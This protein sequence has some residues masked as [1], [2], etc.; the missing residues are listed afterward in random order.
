MSRGQRPARAAT[1]IRRRLAT[2]DGLVLG[3]DFDGTL[4][5]IQADPDR[6]AI[7][8]GNRR[9]LRE[10]TG[11]SGT[12][13]AVVSG[14]ALDDLR[15]RVGLGDVVYV[16]NHGFE[17]DAGDGEFVHR[18]A[19]VTRDALEE[20][21]GPLLDRLRAIPG[22][23]LEDKT[24]TLTVHYRNTPSHLV[25]AVYD[26]VDAVLVSTGAD[27]ER[28]TGKAILELA[29]PV[30][31]N[32]GV[33]VRW[34]RDLAPHDSSVLYVGDD[35]TDEDVFR[36][37]GDRDVGVHV[38]TDET[39]A[40]FRIPSQPDVEAFLTWLSDTIDGPN[41]AQP[42]ARSAPSVRKRARDRDARNPVRFA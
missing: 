16:G 37:L 22:C 23:E 4:T 15:P 17:V 39:A 42:G 9:A 34:L 13:V 2:G 36:T 29:P 10:L 35:T 31:W 26:T 38:G 28:R 41:T 11:T 20:V 8:T 24:Y 18:T 40:G 27:V 3:L 5:P 7:T 25:P 33:A 32:K 21:R 6:P 19:A 12:L 1:E 14:R 30:E